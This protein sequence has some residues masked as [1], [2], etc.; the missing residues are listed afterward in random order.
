[1]HRP[2]CSA[3]VLVEGSRGAELLVV[4]SHGHGGFAGLLLGSVG[5][6]CAHHATCPVVTLTLVHG[7]RDTEHNDAVV[8]AAI[9]RGG[10]R[11]QSDRRERS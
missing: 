8:L 11:S 2:G 1:V 5:Q 9:L 6:H 4:G 10:I 7:A 3:S